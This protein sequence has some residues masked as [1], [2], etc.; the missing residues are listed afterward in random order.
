MSQTLFQGR[1]LRVAVIGAGP[2]GFYAAEELLRADLAVEVDLYE[3][4][5]APYGLVRYGVAPDHQKTKLVTMRFDKLA[6]N[7]HFQF[8]GNVEIGADITLETLKKHYD[9]VLIS[10]GT[11]SGGKLGIPGEDLPHSHHAFDFVNWYNGHPDHQSHAFNLQTDTAVVIGNGNVAIDVAR[12]LAK[13][14]DAL[15]E[16]DIPKGVIDQLEESK[17]QHVQIVG[18]RGPVQASF[19]VKELKEIGDIP[20]CTTWISPEDLSLNEASQSELAQADLRTRKI[21]EAF[22]GFANQ[23]GDGKNLQLTFCHSP[24]ECT[25]DGLTLVRNELTGEAGSQKARA[26]DQT[27][28]L[29]TGL[30]I[31][32]IGYRAKPFD[33]L[34]F[35]ENRG[36]LPNENGRVSRSVYAAGWIKRGP[37]GLIGNNKKCAAETVQ[38]L[39]GDLDDLTPCDQPT[40]PRIEKRTIS[41]SD[42][43]RID[44][45]EQAR[46]TPREKFL[47]L[48]DALTHLP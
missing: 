18:R 23:P 2:A 34:P 16:T 24:V 32:C 4:L 5:F 40:R 43:Q 8:I 1:A 29:K 9:A 27:E 35:D 11:E 30:V 39:L 25:K 41:F 22:K 31:S 44:A 38:T 48:E 21:F 7:E 14:I 37:S 19:T 47:T 3:R 6:A 13:P 26:T 33:G 15:K 28:S 36:L 45:A 10:S 12:I 20:G 42:W 17:I 46:S